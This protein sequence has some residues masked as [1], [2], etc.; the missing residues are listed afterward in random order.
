MPRVFQWLRTEG[1]ACC[2][3]MLRALF[4]TFHHKNGMGTEELN[5]QKGEPF[6]YPTS[7]G[8]RILDV[9]MGGLTVVYFQS[10]HGIFFFFFF[11]E[12]VDR[13]T[14]CTNELV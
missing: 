12:R 7:G 14:H 11:V 3:R 13:H 2:T 9:G 5:K 8:M 6:F 10:E 1:C 4:C